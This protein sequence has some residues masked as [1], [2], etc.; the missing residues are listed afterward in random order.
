MPWRHTKCFL[1]KKWTHKHT[2]F[3]MEWRTDS[4]LFFFS[5]FNYNRSDRI[6]LQPNKIK[7]PARQILIFIRNLFEMNHLSGFHWCGGC[8]FF[9]VFTLIFAKS[10]QTSF[11]TTFQNSFTIFIHLQFN[12]NALDLKRNKRKKKI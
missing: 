1:K 11:S 12:D 9:G 5:L 6:D 2:F 7:K 4:S 8:C 10:S 3:F